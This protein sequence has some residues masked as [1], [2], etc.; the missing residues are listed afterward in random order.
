MLIFKNK[1]ILSYMFIAYILIFLLI[2]IS[3][4]SG[5]EY[6]ITK[7]GFY[8][9]QSQQQ[10]IEKNYIRSLSI[11]SYKYRESLFFDEVDIILKWDKQCVVQVI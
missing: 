4:L 10:F 11:N 3:P 8:R 7:Y 1:P 2:S 5:Q 6:E 9:I